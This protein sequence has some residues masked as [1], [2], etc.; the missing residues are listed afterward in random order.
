[1]SIV[2]Q[3]SG[4][5]NLIDKL[6]KYEKNKKNGYSRTMI[7][8]ARDVINEAENNVPVITGHLRGTGIIMSVR[9]SYG[10]VTHK[11]PG[12]IREEDWHKVEQRPYIAGVKTFLKSLLVSS[13]HKIAV[14]IGFAASY[15]DDVHDREEDPDS[16][17]DNGG[18]FLVKAVNSQKAKIMRNLRQVR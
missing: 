8:F 17:E 11:N 15:A 18:K 16:E 14:M 9:P 6:R 5:K 10:V 1:M 7:N 12:I 4:T 13:G 3:M 2:F